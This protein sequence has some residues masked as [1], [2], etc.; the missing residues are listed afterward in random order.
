MMDVFD[1]RG[2]I[3]DRGMDFPAGKLFLCP[4]AKARTNYVTSHC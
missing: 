2:Q 3:L 1:I 4:F